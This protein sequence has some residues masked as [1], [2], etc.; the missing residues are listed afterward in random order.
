MSEKE[1]S[2]GKTEN[3]KDFRKKKDLEHRQTQW[4]NSNN[5]RKNSE[6]W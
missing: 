4:E 2:G 1:N 5:R 3:T 6:I